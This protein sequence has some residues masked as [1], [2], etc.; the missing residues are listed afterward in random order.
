VAKPEEV[1]ESSIMM[2]AQR[3]S[4]LT[5]LMLQM[6]IIEELLNRKLVLSEE[7][8]PSFTVSITEEGMTVEEGKDPF[9]HAHLATTREQWE[10]IFSGS[11]TYATIFRFELE[12]VRRV[13]YLN[14]SPLVERFCT[15]LQALLLLE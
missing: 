10:K 8:G 2:I 11:K 7:E 14:E 9:A 13:V 6:G 5:P 4:V 15:V 3:W 1:L 12:P